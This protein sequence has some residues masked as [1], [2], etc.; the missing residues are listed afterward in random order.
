VVVTDR[1]DW[2]GWRVPGSEYDRD[3]AKIEFQA[4]LLASAPKLLALVRD[5]NAM[6][7]EDPDQA[8]PEM[9]KLA[10]QAAAMLQYVNDT[11]QAPAGTE[12]AA[13]A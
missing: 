2:G 4:R 8:T 9:M 5:F 11:V 3:P 7:F 12:A 6:V 13:A 10:K 1:Q